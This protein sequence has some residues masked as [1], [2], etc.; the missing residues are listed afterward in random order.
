MGHNRPDTVHVA[1]EAMKLAFADRDAYYAD[2]YFEDVPVKALLSPDYASARRGLIDP[3]QASLE[4]RPGD[5]VHGKVRL[6][7][8]DPRIGRGGPAKDTTTCVVA[9]DQGNVVAATPSGFTGALAG[10]TGVWL[11]SR[12]QSFNNWAGHPN[13]IEPG[14]RPRITLTPTIVLKDRKP[15]YAVSVAGGDQQDQATLQL[16]VNA[17]DF[18]MAPAEA[19]TAPRF[20]TDHHLGSF[21]QK[22]PDLGSLTLAAG[23]D[24][25]LTKGLEARGHRVKVAKGVLA[26]PVMLRIDPKTGRKDAAGDPR[27]RRHAAA[28]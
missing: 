14:K 18:G 17:I 24:P 1:V 6:G 8:P 4:Q 23:H 12:L 7:N 21:R 13:R 20:G 25:G 27:A 19:V 10:K 3:K 5:P 16:L 26:A 9:D 22:P 15:V 28:Y 11:G 2:P